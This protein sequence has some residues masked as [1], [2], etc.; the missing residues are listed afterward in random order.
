MP[1]RQ[2]TRRVFTGVFSVAT[3]ASV[4][5]PSVT[6]LLGSAKPQESFESNWSDVEVEDRVAEQI[7]WNRAWHFATT[8]LSLPNG[9][10]N[11]L[12]WNKPWTAE[13]KNAF[14]YLFQ[15]SHQHVLRS[16]SKDDI[17]DWYISNVTKHYNSYVI[18]QILQVQFF[19]LDKKFRANAA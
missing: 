12:L 3:Q 6:P 9:N 11:S 1:E 17:I 10:S 2:S 7:R 19:V 8:F 16:N 18:P 5:T 15:G 4:P 13:V 14:M